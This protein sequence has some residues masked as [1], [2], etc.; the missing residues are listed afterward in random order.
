MP[1][2]CNKNG[3]QGAADE[4]ALKGAGAK[5]AEYERNMEALAELRA[6]AGGVLQERRTK[7]PVSSEQGVQTGRQHVHKRA[8]IVIDLGDD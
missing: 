3:S 6:L 2:V 1:L 7:E 5:R 8:R 4:Q